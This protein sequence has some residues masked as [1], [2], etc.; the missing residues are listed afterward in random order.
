MAADCGARPQTPTIPN[1]ASAQIEDMKAASKAIE[2]FSES[3]DNYA[4]CQIKSAQSAIDARN[5][6]VQ[7]W[8]QEID[9]F[10]GRLVE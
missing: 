2:T 3:M 10:N 4:D 5:E 8:N 6:I 9:S 7:R 1:G